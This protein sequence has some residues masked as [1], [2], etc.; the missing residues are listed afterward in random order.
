MP[1]LKIDESRGTYECPICGTNNPLNK[2]ICEKCKTAFPEEIF[3]Q[4]NSSAPVS[5]S[6]TTKK[7]LP[8]TVDLK[9]KK[10]NLATTDK[11]REKTREECI[12]EFMLLPMITR[13]MAE[14]FYD[15]EK[16]KFRSISD[17]IY[18][19][20]NL[21]S[22][23]EQKYKI[24]SDRILI[25]GGLGNRDEVIECPFCKTKIPLI[26]DTCPICGASMD[27]EI[28]DYDRKAL[29]KNIEKFLGE[30]MDYLSGDKSFK[31][32]SVSTKVTIEHQPVDKEIE[33]ELELITK[34][35]PK[36][37]LQTGTMQQRIGTISDN[38]KKEPLK[39]EPLKSEPLKS[40]P[41]KS[42]VEIDLDELL[43][44]EPE[45]AEKVEEKKKDIF[46]DLFS[47]PI[48]E[49]EKV[50]LNLDLSD[51]EKIGVDKKSGDIQDIFSQVL[52][53]TKTESDKKPEVTIFKK[54]AKEKRSEKPTAKPDIKSHPK[55]SEYMKR[56]EFLKS[57]GHDVTELLKL[58]SEDI[59]NYETKS[60]AIIQKMIKRKK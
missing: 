15:N 36:V 7:S 45:S 34:E 28:I 53:D 26:N 58:L 40:E 10:F 43:T 16:F 14:N 5:N 6:D 54:V 19:V 37:E 8:K 29:D 11:K 35:K 56:I 9:I 4:T 42:G 41:S 1:K 44:I 2:H 20:L 12:K 30:V 39:S 51:L 46:D 33:K 38:L 31:E 25:S 24:I 52:P 47:E 50:N 48:K 57:K 17:I 21:P 49:P 27:Y 60:K 22:G 59:E 13:E 55:Y 32:L 18:N 3:G 23:Q